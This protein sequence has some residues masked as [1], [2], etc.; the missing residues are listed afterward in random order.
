M[1]VYRR[2]PFPAFSRANIIR[3][4]FRVIAFEQLFSK[5]FIQPICYPERYRYNTFSSIFITPLIQY[6]IHAWLF[7][8][9]RSSIK[10]ILNVQWKYTEGALSPH[11][12]VSSFYWIEAHFRLKKLNTRVILLW[13]SAE[14]LALRSSLCD[15]CINNNFKCYWIGYVCLFIYE[16]CVLYYLDSKFKFKYLAFSNKKVLFGKLMHFC[17]T[18][19]LIFHKF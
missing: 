5:D 13:N 18:N 15:S 17:F 10:K 4:C 16:K 6:M 14:A 7:R 8:L 11:F 19:L 12:R 9:L 3:I 1:K 2:R